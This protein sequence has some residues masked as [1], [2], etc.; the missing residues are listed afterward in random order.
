MAD[1]L[2]PQPL[3]ITSEQKVYFHS[4]STPTYRTV[5]TTS[6]PITTIPTIDISSI[7]SSDPSVRLGLAAELI[8][9]CSTC[10][11]FYLTGHGL[12]EQLQEDTFDVM[13]KFFELPIEEKM[14]AHVQNNPAIRGYEPQGETRLDLRTKAGSS[15]SQF[16]TR[17]ADE[18]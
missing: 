16:P 17:Y 14:D 9:A 15:S 13:K 7:D 8:S 2:I 11:F 4:G 1:V 12:S 6:A 5:N 10:G 3:P 18:K